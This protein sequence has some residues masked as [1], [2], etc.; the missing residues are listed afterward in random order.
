V[1]P[2]VRRSLMV[3]SVF[4]VGY[5]M[6]AGNSHLAT[7]SAQGPGGNAPGAEATKAIADASAALMGAKTALA[8]ESRYTPAT[9]SLNASAIMSGGVD[10]L[11]D[12]E[13]GRGVD[14]ETFAALY[15]DDAVDEVAVEI[16]K[17]EQGRLTYKGKVVRMYSVARLK[18]WY[19]ERLRYSGE[20]AKKK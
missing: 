15:A 4:G 1:I 18:Q 7:V 9:K 19:Q 20:D 2:F 14:P 5:M 10:A 16:G 8:A 6:G 13:S 3:L 17:D 12:L 11:A